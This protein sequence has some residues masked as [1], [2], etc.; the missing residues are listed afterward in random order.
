[1]I[2]LHDLQD[3][4]VHVFKIV[5]NGF[6]GEGSGLYGIKEAPVLLFDLA[7]LLY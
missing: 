5:E 7:L 2:L 6:E 4:A 3:K 1:M